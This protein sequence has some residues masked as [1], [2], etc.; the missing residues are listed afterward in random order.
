MFSNDGMAVNIIKDDVS[1][2]GRTSMG[3][4]GMNLNANDIIFHKPMELH[5]FS[6]TENA[7]LL[8][9]S[10]SLTGRLNEYLANKVF[11]LTDEQKAYFSA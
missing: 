5:K 1:A 10:Y 11:S 7:T 3:V 9:F 4:K 8:I 2:T 6:I